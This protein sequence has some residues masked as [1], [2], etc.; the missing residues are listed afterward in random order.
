MS[1]VYINVI[2]PSA[3]G[4]LLFQKQHLVV[5][6][7]AADMCTATGLEAVGWPGGGAPDARIGDASKNIC[8]SHN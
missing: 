4:L 6:S 3:A 1:V 2:R 7:L 8:S 5:Q